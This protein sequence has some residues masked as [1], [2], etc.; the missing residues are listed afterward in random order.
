MTVQTQKKKKYK[1]F[2]GY[3]FNFIYFLPSFSSL[4]SV[5]EEV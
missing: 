5:F 2:L 4:S 3:V 1:N